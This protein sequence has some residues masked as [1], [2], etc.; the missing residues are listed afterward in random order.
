M[1]LMWRL[2]LLAVL[3]LPRASSAQQEDRD[4]AP[5]L[6][7][8]KRARFLD[9]SGKKL[10]E[11]KGHVDLAEYMDLRREA[12]A[13][14]LPPAEANIVHYMRMGLQARYALNAR[15]FDLRSANCVTW[16]ERTL[17][18]GLT[19]NWADARKLQNRLRYRDGKVGDPA[20]KNHRTL[21]D[22]VANNTWLWQEVTEQLGVP[23]AEMRWATK[24]GDVVVRHTAQ[25]VP[26]EQFASAEAS[27]KSGDVILFVGEGSTRTGRAVGVGH[28]GLISVSPGKGAFAYSCAPGAGGGKADTH[29]LSTLVADLKDDRGL[30]GFKFLRVRPNA[31]ALVAG[32]LGKMTIPAASPAEID[33]EL[34]LKYDELITVDGKTYAKKTL[35]PGDTLWSLFGPRWREIMRL[36]MNGELRR[37]AT[38]VDGRLKSVSADT[39]VYFPWIEDQ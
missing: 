27:L 18:L 26:K 5:N 22:W 21:E 9:L 16:T 13:G 35:R 34:A 3:A 11:M 10:H 15:S 7:P 1:R 2:G 6:P 29:H 19:D 37:N 4:V 8:D 31:G 20:A 12:F 17:A 28:M 14:K 33:A 24:S 23:T 25:Y 39:V 32:E 38:W 36:P 30:L